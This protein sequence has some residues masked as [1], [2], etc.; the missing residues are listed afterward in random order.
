MTEWTPLLV[1]GLYLGASLLTG[2]LPGFRVSR[3]V[4]G[5]TSYVLV[6]ALGFFCWP[7]LF[8]KAFA[9]SSDRAIRRTVV[10]YPTFQ[11]FIVPILFIGF[12]A[13]LA[14][15]GVKPADSL[16]PYLLTQLELSPWLVGLVCAGIL[17]A[18]MSSGDTILHA[19]ASVGVR[20]GIRKALRDRLDDRHERLL[21]RLLVLV[22]AII[23]YYFAIVSDVSI[24][25][26]L[27]GAY[28]GVAQIFPLLL[29][30]FYW[31]RVN[32]PGAVAGLLGGIAVNVL[33]LQMPQLK[34]WP[35]H[36]GIYGLFANVAVMWSVSMLTAPPDRRHVKQFQEY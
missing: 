7:H 25:A 34:P 14:F 20:D 10:M 1:C 29:A 32:G 19:A 3:S 17:A 11:L 26:L 27:A 2:L 21:I 31:P 9:A 4:T 30:A 35:L 33:L 23:S 24:V 8:M 36:E 28:G 5:F 6:S 22:L 13:I 16:V 12:S 15:P 18:S